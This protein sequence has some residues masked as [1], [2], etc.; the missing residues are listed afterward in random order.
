MEKGNLI[1]WLKTVGDPVRSG[2]VLAEIE[3]DKATM[4]VEALADGVLSRI[5]VPAGTQ[6]VAVSQVIG[7][8]TTKDEVSPTRS[9]S[10]PAKTSAIVSSS[11]TTATVAPV[12]GGVR[13]LAKATPKPN[14][15][16]IGRIFASPIARRLMSEAGLN[17]TSLIGTGPRGRILERDVSAALATR[18]IDEKA[19]RELEEH[20]SKAALAEPSAPEL[21]HDIKLEASFEGGSFVEVPHDPMRL[22]IARRLSESKRMIPHFYLSAECIID[23]LLSLRQ[24]FND[25]APSR[26]D[27]ERAYR[28]SVNDFVIRALALALN[29]V[30]DANV[31]FSETA[32]LRHRHADIGVAVAITGGLM[33]PIV[34]RAE[35]KSIATISNEIKEL[36]ARAK[37]RRLKLEE[38]QG[39]TASVSNLGMYGVRDFAAI[40][41]PPQASILAVGAGTRRLVVTND[42]PAVAT[43]MIVTLSVDHRAIDGASA[44]ELLSAFKALIENPMTILA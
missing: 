5:L 36:A 29:Q 2:E 34:R 41:N 24:Q 32:L 12:S 3:T 21:A 31:S 22:T 11:A 6:D 38:Y 23:S 30:P 37:T 43:V 40:V 20:P 4:E 9:D 35:T 44:A 26:P 1:Q 7:L 14:G 27:G 39:G 25:A 17:A 10:L 28:L 33:T 8:M 15:H 18:V 16:G 42:K 13:P 19:K